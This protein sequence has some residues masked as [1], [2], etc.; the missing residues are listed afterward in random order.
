MTS[1]E[2]DVSV[3]SLALPPGFERLAE[4]G[5]L[6]ATVA[7]AL[8]RV[9]QELAE[10]VANADQLADLTSRHLLEA[11][12]KR[13]R[14]LLTVLSSLLGD[15]GVGTG[16]V[17]EV[18][19]AVR[20]AA[21]VMELTHLATLY[22]DDVMD[23]APVRRGAP[24]AHEL[25]GN[26]VAI[27]AGD[28]I[29]ARASQLMASLGPEAVAIQ[30]RTFERLVMGQL[31]ETVGPQQDQDPLE[32]Y[33]RVISGKTGSLIAA[34][35]RLG[36]FFG[37]ADEATVDTLE[38]YGEKVGMA[39]QLA[40]DVI[41]LTSA[42][43]TS[44]KVPGTDLK[45]RVPTLPVLLLRQEAARGDAAA[46]SALELVDGPLDTDDQLVAAVAAV[47]AH[48]VIESAWEITRGWADD[49]RAA[50]APLPDSP[51]KDALEA[52]ADYVVRRDA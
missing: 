47:S 28:L 41:D 37:G 43:D 20:S 3:G 39:F 22:H 7:T 27:L 36:A 44:G 38:D 30:A 46:R 6:L 10:A 31:W 19:A 25:W 5:E 35:G 9:E 49:A 12:G 42:S 4:N 48:P 45:E 18:S 1:P 40:D 52:F 21:V 13:V 51:V 26:S 15:P 34:A 24:A 16:Q 33:L 14:P 32:H 17:G 29:F 2:P 23:E 50:L 8:D 11:G